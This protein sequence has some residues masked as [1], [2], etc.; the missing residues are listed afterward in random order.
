MYCN[1]EGIR[2]FYTKNY[3]NKLAELTEIG[4]SPVLKL[5]KVSSK[6]NGVYICYGYSTHARTYFLAKAR[7]ELDSKIIEELNE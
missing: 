5:L 3:D 2:W 7:I 1:G 4:N 6:D